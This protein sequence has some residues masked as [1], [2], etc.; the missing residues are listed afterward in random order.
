MYIDALRFPHGD[1]Y[2]PLDSLFAH[3]VC[4]QQVLLIVKAQERRTRDYRIKEVN[5]SPLP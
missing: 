5:A 1:N 4:V 2:Y 3:T